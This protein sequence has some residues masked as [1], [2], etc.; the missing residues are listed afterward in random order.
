MGQRTHHRHHAHATIK[1]RAMEFGIGRGSSRVLHIYRKRALLHLIFFCC[2][3]ILCCSSVVFRVVF[4]NS[5]PKQSNM[6]IFNE[7]IISLALRWVDASWPTRTTTQST[8]A[9]NHIRP[10]RLTRARSVQSKPSDL[11]STP[12]SFAGPGRRPDFISFH[13]FP[14]CYFVFLK[15][16]KRNNPMDGLVQVNKN[17][18]RNNTY[19][20]KK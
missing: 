20:R 10:T 1:S 19:T 12:L 7:M 14:F 11:V 15:K 16:L 5:S 8:R 6:Q 4:P 13:F 3:S 17:N 2:F 18:K 9:Q